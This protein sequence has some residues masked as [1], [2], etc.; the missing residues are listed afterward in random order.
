M[1][2]QRAQARRA[3][4]EAQPSGAGARKVCERRRAPAR[5]AALALGFAAAVP[6]AWAE[7]PVP[8]LRARVTDAAD[9]LPPA[10]EARLEAQLAEFERETAH[11]VAVLTVPTTDG[12]PIEVFSLRVVESWKLGQKDLDTGL[13]LVVAAQDRRARVEVG[14]GLEGVVPDA[15]AKR[16]LEDVMF[17]RFRAGDPAG[18]IEAG[19]AALL[20]AARGE[21]VPL[22]RRPPARGGAPHEDPLAVLLFA[23]GFGAIGTAMLFGRALRRARGLRA[24]L[25]GFASGGLCGFLLGSAGW[26]ALAFG[27]GG[28]AGFVLPALAEAAGRGGAWHP[29]G[30]FGRGGF[31]GG[32]FGGGGG[33][34]GGGGG[35]GGGGASGGW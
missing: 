7:I 3:R 29:G 22:E 23:V 14:Y 25:A 27:L 12:E 18:G 30:G 28:L 11:Q 10:A 33:V 16:V 6:I 5:L 24:L 20:Q 21:V 35:F 13:L 19:V 32:G 17:P 8:P 1:R 15:V 2:A 4:S 9:L 26:A 34:G 31:G